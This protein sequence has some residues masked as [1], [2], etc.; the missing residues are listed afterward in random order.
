LF[1]IDQDLAQLFQQKLLFDFT[2]KELAE[3][4][5]LSERQVI[6]KWN[7]AKSLILTLIESPD[8]YK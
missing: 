4:H 2:F 3:M 8:G 7:Q 1:S 6:R 5:D